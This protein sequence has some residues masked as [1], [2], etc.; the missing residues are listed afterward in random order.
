[1]FSADCWGLQICKNL[2]LAVAVAAAVVVVVASVAIVIA[3]VA[4]AMAVV[5]ALPHRISRLAVN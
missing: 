3:A 1:M 4:V 5:E 2:L